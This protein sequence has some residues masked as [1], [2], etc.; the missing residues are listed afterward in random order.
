VRVDGVARATIGVNGV[1]VIPELAT[2]SH[3]V[4]LIDIAPNCTLGTTSIVAVVRGGKTTN[5]DFTVGCV[6]T[7][8]RVT[9]ATTG[10]DLDADGY[11]VV[12]NGVAAGAIGVNGSVQVTRLA[13]GASTVTLSGMAANCPVAGDNPR[14]VTTLF[15]VIVQVSF[16]VTCAA[17]T[18][19]AEIRASTTG[20]DPDVN[21]YTVALNGGVPAPLPS[22]GVVRFSGL[23][24]AD[25]SISLQGAATNCA[26][27]GANPRS[28]SVTAGGAKRDTARTTFAVSCVAVTGVIEVTTATTGVAV[29]TDGY[30]ITV[31]EGSPVALGINTTLPLAGFAAGSYGLVL[32]G[33]ADNCSV[34]G[35]NGRSVDV[36]TGGTTRDTARTTFQV[37]CVATDASLRIVTATAGDEIDPDGYQVFGELRCDVDGY[38]DYAWFR[39]LGP[40]DTVTVSD[41]IVGD[42]TVQLDGA[43]RNCAL[44]GANPRTVTTPAGAT[45]EVVFTITCAETARVRVTTTTSGAEPDLNGYGV[46][47]HGAV[48]DTSTTIASNATV[49]IAN[50]APGDYTVSIDSVARNCTVTGA[51]P[52]TVTAPSGVTADV[53]FAVT[54]AQTA[55]VQVTLTTSGIDPDLD[56]YRVT[57]DGAVVDT[58]TTIASNAT[59]TIANLVPGDYAVSV[60]GVAVN[61]TVAGLNPRTVSAVSGGTT[62]VAFGVDCVAARQLAFVSNGDGDDEIFL[63]KSNGT[64]L[65][66]L[67]NNFVSD[68]NPAWSPDG[69]KIAFH[70]HR[71]ANTDIYVMNADG[72]SPTRLTTAV[73]A[74]YQPSWSPDG[75]KIAFT[76]AR[77]GQAEIYVMNADGSNQVRLTID[78]AGPIADGDPAWSP[79]GTRIAFWSARDG[80]SEIYMM[81]ADGSNPQRLTTSGGNEQ[82]AWS[83]DGTKLA[84][85]HYQCDGY[86]SYYCDADLYVVNVDGSGIAQLTSGYLFDDEPDWSRDG[87]WIAFATSYCDGYY[88]CISAVRPNGTGQ[89]VIVIGPYYQPAWRP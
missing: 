17:V 66:R 56:G 31:N 48:L 44:A 49:T 47:L 73:E 9:A 33:T 25:Y 75:T 21:G 11:A 59:A 74:D 40:N 71:V 14:S 69:S 82:P 79:D 67:T 35:D 29:D 26:L 86:Y 23:A 4:A 20:V 76:S 19:I 32:G 81:N 54:C 42:H 52:R 55:S 38:C 1:A 57:L 63:I 43:A 8:I 53:A 22:N 68:A 80:Q 58:S 62:P 18:G 45:T 30:T 3:D 10:L 36:T 65:T 41:L 85:R 83:P 72:T 24:P 6:P 77:D 2:G 28:L 87:T 39:T 84:F 70:S 16:N 51:N 64:G 89:S 5:M 46:T 15:G 50:L 27:G 12:I 61:C 34:A 78:D 60:D 88:N 37:T 7:G 13:T